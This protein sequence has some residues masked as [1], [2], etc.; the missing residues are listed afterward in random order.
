[1]ICFLELFWNNVFAYNEIT[2]L[3]VNARCVVGTAPRASLRDQ[4]RGNTFFAVSATFELMLCVRNFISAIRNGW[5]CVDILTEAVLIAYDTRLF[6]AGGGG[7]V[8]F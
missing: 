2:K 4:E 5:F 3:G 7:G 1:M 8:F 6:L